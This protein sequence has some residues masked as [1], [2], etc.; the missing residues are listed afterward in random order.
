LA[1]LIH[2]SDF[3]PSVLSVFGLYFSPDGQRILAIY[4]P[5]WKEEN[6]ILI[7]VA[8]PKSNVQKLDINPRY[9]ENDP[10]KSCIRCVGQNVGIRHSL[11][12]LSNGKFCT[13][14]PI[15]YG[16]GYVL[17]FAPERLI[18][19]DFRFYDWNCQ[20]IGQIEEA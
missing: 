11:L 14:P 16:S 9:W 15:A 7:S 10:G 5:S 6:V 2:N 3:E 8:D 18:G 12:Q 17:P 1:D 19:S 20:H 13:L 4:G